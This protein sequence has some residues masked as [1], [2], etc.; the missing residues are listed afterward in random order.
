MAYTSKRITTEGHNETLQTNG[1]YDND[2]R[3]VIMDEEPEKDIHS[4]SLIIIK[5]ISLMQENIWKNM[6]VV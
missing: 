5:L 1:W 2:R 6:T 4:I 3:V